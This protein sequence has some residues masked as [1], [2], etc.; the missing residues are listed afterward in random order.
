M[1]SFSLSPLSQRA[2]RQARPLCVFAEDE[3]AAA[4]QGRT[5]GRGPVLRGL[6]SVYK[7]LGIPCGS[8]KNAL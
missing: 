4:Q 8:N 5:G 3:K 2:R 1:S 6:R 7:L